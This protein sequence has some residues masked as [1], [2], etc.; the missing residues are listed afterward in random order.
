MITKTLTNGNEVTDKR[1]Q[2][3][4]DMH[5]YYYN[6]TMVAATATMLGNEV[7]DEL[8]DE[9]ADLLSALQEL[10]SLRKEKTVILLSSN[11]KS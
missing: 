8:R 4:I 5:E 9:Y 3:L 10:L 7:R 11:T 2:E 6:E 1:L